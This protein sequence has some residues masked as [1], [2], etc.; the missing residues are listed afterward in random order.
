MVFQVVRQ[1]IL[2]DNVSFVE[3]H[4]LF[5]LVYI[6]EVFVNINEAININQARRLIG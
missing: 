6:A 4:Q 5:L 3:Y 2:I 1:S